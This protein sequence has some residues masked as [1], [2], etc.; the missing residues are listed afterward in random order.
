MAGCCGHVGNEEDAEHAD[1]SVKDFRGR[2]QGLKV[3]V[4]K[5]NIREATFVY[6]P[7]RQF[8][9][10]FCQ[11]DA[12]NAARRADDFGSGNG[13]SAAPA[14]DIEDV[15]AW[16]ERDLRHGAAADTVPE[17]ERRG[18]EGIGGGV[19]GGGGAGLGGV[20]D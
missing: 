10:I 12:E 19:V 6:F 9:E 1:H 16:G 3:G 7:A 5:F 17:S 13:G 11:V 18:I 14:A 15:G 8:Q 20:H 2:I 4:K